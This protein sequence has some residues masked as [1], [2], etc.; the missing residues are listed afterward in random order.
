MKK[1]RPIST[2]IRPGD[3]FKSNSYGSFKILSVINAKDVLCEF[4]DTGYKVTSQAQ[5]IRSGMVKDPLSPSILGVGFFGVGAFSAKSNI[6]A[7]QKWKNMLTRCYS[8]EYQLNNKTYIGCS[9][10][11]EWHNFQNFAKWYYDN[12]PID[13]EIN[14]L[15]KDIKVNGN[16]IYSPSTCM[17]VTPSAN[18]VEAHCSV[19]AFISPSG[20]IVKVLNLSEFARENGLSQPHLSSVCSGKR[21]SHKGWRSA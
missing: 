12:K 5:H 9:V 19:R 20:N 17:I 21:K 16:K 4:L 13:I 6:E 10:C 1:G 18:T 7:Y 14:H 8:D 2:S 3:V 15:D 11:A